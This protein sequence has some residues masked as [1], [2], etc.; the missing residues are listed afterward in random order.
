ML[1]QKQ[2]KELEQVLNFTPYG[3]LTDR[4]K[5]IYS[6]AARNGYNLGMQHRKQIDRIEAVRFGREVITPNKKKENLNRSVKFTEVSFKQAE[7]IV[8][9]T[10]AFYEVSMEDF[11][12]IKRFV[13]VVMCRSVV[14][15][16]IKELLNPPL[17]GITEFV[18]KRDHT[19]IL[20]HL[21]MKHYKNHLWQDGKRIWEDFEEIKGSLELH[22]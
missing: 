19:T 18:G 15:N 4:E 9:K 1:N 5:L 6:V 16:L 13:P 11:V 8:A 14:I 10:I 3:D 20:H 17:Q 12:S 21:R 2:N 7:E 22:S